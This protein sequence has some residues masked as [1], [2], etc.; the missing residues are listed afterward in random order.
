MRKILFLVLSFASA[1]LMAQSNAVPLIY[2][3][4]FPASVAPG[5]GAFAL[6]VR[7]TGF[8]SSSVVNWNGK[9]LKTKLISATL[10][11]A[12]VP[13]AAVAAPATGSV[14]VKNPGTIA[15]NV[16]Y[17]PV[18]TPSK[19]VTVAT[20]SAVIEGGQITIG[21][22]NNDNR[23]DLGI[24][25]VNSSG[26]LSL[27][28]YLSQGNNTF[29]KV[30]GAVSSEIGPMYLSGNISADFNNDGNLDL[31]NCASTGGP[32][33]GCVV[34][35]GDGKGGFAKPAPINAFAGTGVAA[36]ID[37]DGT[38]DAL[39]TY[40]DGY[41]SYIY[42]QHGNGDGTFE[43]VGSH[44]ITL[45]YYFGGSPVVADFNEDGKLD[46]AAP[47]YESNYVA[48]LLGNGDGTFQTEVDYPISCS[49]FSSV[50]ADINRDGNLDIVSACTNGTVAVLLG[51]GDGTFVSGTSSA[52]PYDAETKLQIADLNGDGKLDLATV[53][54][55]NSGN[56]TLN[57]AL[58]NA[59]G[60]FQTP[61][62]IPAGQV[63]NASSLL[64][65]ADFNHDGLLDF[66][67]SGSINH[68][69]QSQ[70]LL[71]TPSK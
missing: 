11:E 17:L 15:S 29:K 19:T 27:D 25:P 22:F 68:P 14:T 65:I 48:V 32:N 33:A 38:L 49:A 59:N 3:P 41:G 5:H 64:A 10:L 37:R 39:T 9:P 67:I 43:F 50:V 63:P 53:T 54:A 16:I 58:G 7:G 26:A 42:F 18:R 35:L 6:K 34:F 51:K 55:D 2:Q 30:Q 57:I 61:I 12:D 45:N 56:Q 4:L 8:Q 40:Y 52:L 70:I 24:S 62:A 46:F 36:D 31:A 60:T 13:A 20:D 44:F 28:T 1:A 69:S 71:Q 21:D 23:P 47:A 66:A